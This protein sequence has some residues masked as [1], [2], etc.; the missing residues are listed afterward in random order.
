M[1]VPN[2]VSFILYKSQI[3]AIKVLIPVFVFDVK[4]IH[5]ELYILTSSPLSSP[6]RDE[7]QREPIELSDSSLISS[8]VSYRLFDLGELVW[9]D[10]SVGFVGDS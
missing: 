6:P 10:F 2:I 1:D 8:R 5:W 7:S 9:N 4:H 3:P